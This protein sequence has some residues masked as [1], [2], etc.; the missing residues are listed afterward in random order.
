MEF[1]SSNF[2]CNQVLEFQSLYLES[3]PSAAMYEKSYM[4]VGEV[5][6]VRVTKTDFF[7]TSRYV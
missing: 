2:G 4:H 3:L 1:R 7:I 6:H 5:N